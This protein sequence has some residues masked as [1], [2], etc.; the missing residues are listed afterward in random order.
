MGFDENKVSD[1][2]IE[3]SNMMVDSHYWVLYFISG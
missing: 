2:Q 1:D 3:F